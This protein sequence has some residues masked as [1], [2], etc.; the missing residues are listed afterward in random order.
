MICLDSGCL[1][2]EI[3]DKEIKRNGFGCGTTCE[4]DYEN[5]DE[6]TGLSLFVGW[7]MV[8]LLL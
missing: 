5:V 1:E 8:C 3:I 6:S 7:R 4:I 2:T